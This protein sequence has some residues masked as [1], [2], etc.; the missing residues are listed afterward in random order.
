MGPKQKGGGQKQ[1]GNAAEEVEETLQAVVLADTFETRFEPFTLD[2]PRCLLPL[3]N[4]PLIEYTLEFLANA[5][6]EEVF[7]YGGAHSDQLEKYINASKWRALS[8]P[9]R[10][11][12]F[13]K[14]T[15]TSVGDVMRDL[16][17]K[18]LITGDFILV[19]GDVISNLPIEGALTKHRLRRATDKNAI[20][21]I[22]LREAGRKHRTKSTS[23]SPVFVIDPTKDR[24]LH[25]EEIDERAE[26]DQPTRLNIDTDIILSHAELD[27]RQ[28]LI[29]CSIDICT[30][31]VLSLWSDSFDYQSPRKHFLYG[32]LKDYELNG[33]TLHTYIITEN[34][35]ARVR[36][37]KAYD[38]VSKDII[39][40]WTYPLCPDTNLLPGHTYDLRKGSL[41]QEQGVTLA[42]SC[43]VGRRTVIGTGTSIGDRTTVHNT[44]LGRHCKIGKNVKLDGAYIW[45]H[46]V[47]GDGSD[48]R[49]A[50]VADGVVVGKKCTV[51]PG[52]LLS[53]GVKIADGVTVP[54]GQRITKALR[55]GMD[56]ASDPK[57][58]GAGGEGYEFVPGDE[59]DEDEDAASE[60]S[61]GLV[62]RM[63]NLSLSSASISTL[64]S[65]LSEGSW[66]RSGRSSF[67]SG[68]EEQDNFY[69]E[70]SASA[71]DML[72]D[73]N[74]ADVVVLELVSMR[75][76]ANASDQ[77]MRRAV[78]VSFMKRIQQLMEGGK[79]AG[80]AVHD[81]FSKYREVVD[82][83][84]LLDRNKEAKK[85][86][87]DLLLL[88][89]QDLVHRHKGDT[90]LLFTAKELY[91]LELVD[92]EAYE[93][94][95]RDERSTESEEMRTVRAQAQQ[96][97]DWLADAEEEESS[98]EEEDESEED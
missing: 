19:S 94:W 69:H 53:Y 5:G 45:D 56:V 17:G 95:W 6:V 81:V 74:A 47:I 80:E 35:A 24:C 49:G 10:Q 32:V 87:V 77:A 1:K 66:P 59:D 90:I 15:S 14:S 11:L 44:V 83:C 22:V 71:F 62:Y 58:V 7:L 55:D 21:T 40:R 26:D 34:Y 51:A 36:N 8:S 98:E 50:I 73:D 79:G 92:E 18:H 28:D 12:R 54:S 89:Q 72:R 4:T 75:M 43:V 91:E 27:I 42:R 97:V 23:I 60:A 70:A 86:Q 41:Y 61:S 48:V 88:L 52:A 13:L 78:V 30:P 29:D 67:S 76:T 85:D 2:K 46:V 16:D 68:D 84:C 57:V 20:M 31:D 93:L 33:K 39:S 3:A 38:A 63:P 64:S 25:Y 9:F 96:F 37:L 82:R 65:E